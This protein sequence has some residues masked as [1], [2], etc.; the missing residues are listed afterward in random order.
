[1]S[2]SLSVTR[3]RERTEEEDTTTAAAEQTDLVNQRCKYLGKGISILRECHDL[4][5]V[6][7]M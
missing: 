3:P 6:A 4:G 5:N 2:V 1:M 7:R